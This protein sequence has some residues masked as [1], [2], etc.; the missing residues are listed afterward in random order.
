[1]KEHVT[2]GCNRQVRMRLQ[3]QATVPWLSVDAPAAPVV[4]MAA[5]GGVNGPEPIERCRAEAGQQLPPL[6]QRHMVRIRR[7][8]R[9]QPAGRLQDS[10]PDS[11]PQGGAADPQTCQGRPPGCSPQMAR[12]LKTSM[13][14]WF[15]GQRQHRH[16]QRAPCGQLSVDRSVTPGSVLIPATPQNRGIPRLSGPLTA[17]RLLRV[18]RRSRTAA[19]GR[20]EVSPCRAGPAPAPCRRRPSAAPGCPSPAGTGGRPRGRGSR[21]RRL[22]GRRRRPRGR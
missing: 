3:Q 5:P 18:T 20:T 12:A 1:M 11:P 14:Q 6:Q 2:E 10:G 22:R 7:R 13:G 17:K 19:S 4:D 9:I 16:P 15:P 8:E 21:R